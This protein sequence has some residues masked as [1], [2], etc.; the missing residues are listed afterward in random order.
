MKFKNFNIRYKTVKRFNY[1]ISVLAKNG[2]GYFIHRLRLNKSLFFK[3][4]FGT[5]KYTE[6]SLPEALRKSFEEL[7]ATFIKF[8]QVLSTRYDL[9]PPSYINELSKLQDSV[10]PINY[11]IILNVIK[12]HYGDDY[13]KIF[14]HIETK[15]VG[16]AS[17]CQVYNSVLADGRE[18]ILKIKR[19]GIDKIIEIDIEIIKIIIKLLK[20]YLPELGIDLSEMVNSFEQILVGEL[21]LLNEAHNLKRF[22]NNFKNFKGV[23]IPKVYWEYCNEDIIVMEKIEGTKL[24]DLEQI[25]NN[26]FDMEKIIKTAD[27]AMLKQIFIDGLFHADPHPGNIFITPAGEI[28]FIDFGII[29][30]FS[31]EMK[32]MLFDL[33]LAIVNKDTSRIVQIMYE[34]NS[35]KDDVDE[36]SLKNEIYSAIDEFIDLP[37]KDI[38]IK[39]IFE[40][41]ISLVRRFNIRVPQDYLVLLRSL[42]ILEGVGKKVSPSFNIL[43]ELKPLLIDIVKKKISAKNLFKELKKSGSNFLYFSKDLPV[44]LKEIMRKIKKGKLQIEFEHKGLENIERTLIVSSSIVTIGLIASAILISL[45]FIL[46][47]YTTKNVP[48]L[49]IISS[50]GF[51]IAFII[52]AYVIGK[53]FKNLNNQK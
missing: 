37:L 29:G 14:T 36:F 5:L 35:V 7:G 17:I 18:V 27:Q 6:L 39:N 24:I 26:N 15:P 51:I 33:T 28:A 43:E 19:P 38:Y 16:S 44:D 22:Y 20:K 41:F 21:N 10:T 52:A 45:S 8:G 2:F 34:L 30:K 32:N 3:L 47:I 48:E 53:S 9:I 4:K 23:V 40:R 31:G 12:S 11:E 49:Y 42:V 25:Q 50:A 13:Q 46:M 1:I